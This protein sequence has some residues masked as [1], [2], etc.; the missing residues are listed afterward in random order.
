MNKNRRD[1]IH[2]SWERPEIILYI[3][4][5]LMYVTSFANI[6]ILKLNFQKTHTEFLTLSI[7]QVQ[8]VRISWNFKKI[9]R[10]IFFHTYVQA[11]LPECFVF[12]NFVRGGGRGRFLLPENTVFTIFKIAVSC[13]SFLFL[14]TCYMIN[15][16][17]ESFWVWCHMK[18][19]STPYDAKFSVFV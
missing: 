6:S 7:S 10:I 3:F 14:E 16:M 2:L 4:N 15:N 11:G 12:Y 17:P 8:V 13:W 1:L 19:I 5:T 9:Y 18:S